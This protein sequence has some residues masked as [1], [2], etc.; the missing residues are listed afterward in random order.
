M[1]SMENQQI[2][3][4]LKVLV[5]SLIFIKAT[6]GVI[7][8]CPC[9]QLQICDIYCCCDQLCDPASITTWQN[10]NLCTYQTYNTVCYNKGTMFSISERIAG[11]Q[12]ITDYSGQNL[13][14]INVDQQTILSD[15]IQISDDDQKKFKL[16]VS[17]QPPVSLDTTPNLIDGL[18]K[19]YSTYSG[20]LISYS[21]LDDLYN[22]NYNNNQNTKCDQLAGTNA[23]MR[24]CI[25]ETLHI[26]G[27]TPTNANIPITGAQQS[28]SGTCTYT[29][30]QTKCIIPYLK[31]GYQKNPIF[32]QNTQSTNAQSPNDQ[33]LIS[34]SKTND[35]KIIEPYFQRTEIIYDSQD[36]N[37]WMIENSMPTTPPFFPELPPDIF[38]PI[39]FE[40]NQQSGRILQFYTIIM[41]L[42]LNL[43]I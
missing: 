30:L 26:F 32:T 29:A 6:L 3:N 42:I 23:N 18:E 9:D 39:W 10:N 14:C 12:S 43:F 13:K 17:S 27:K 37:S 38:Y 36:Y 19:H 8:S 33:Y 34:S 22:K 4:I 11:I 28:Q 35:P 20:F 16:Y 40:S 25:G 5:I 1:N 21:S 15:P 2:R 7:S 41:L 24:L 31:T